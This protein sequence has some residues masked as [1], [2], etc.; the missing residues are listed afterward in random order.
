MKLNDIAPVALFVYNR[1]EHTRRTVEALAQNFG[2]EATHLYV[3]SDAPLSP[4]VA[5]AVSAVRDYV[6]DIKGFPQVKIVKRTVNFGLARNIIE[7]VTEVCNRHGRAIVMEDDIVTDKHFLNFMNAALQRYADD[8]NVWHISGWNY[9]IN[10]NDLG[11]AFFWRVMNCWGWATW[12]DR[13]RHFRKS[14]QGLIQ[15]WDKNRIKRF[16]LDGAHDFWAQV[17]ANHAGRMD[18]WAIFWYAAIFEHEGLCLNPVR[19]LVQNIGL[20]GSGQNCGE[21]SLYSN[22]ETFDKA[23]LLP[24]SIKESALAVSRISTFLS[25]TK[26]GFFERVAQKARSFFER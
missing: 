11:D 17:K 15:T 2:A 10:S 6:H 23:P 9:P 14:P 20:D 18:T 3:F 26:P 7:G 25:E 12:G 16:N 21:T 4:E 22:S 24:D 1:P 5:P 13:W 8:K 19:S